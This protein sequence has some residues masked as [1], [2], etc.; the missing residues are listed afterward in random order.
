MWAVAS[1]FVEV[2]GSVQ[3]DDPAVFPQ[4][5]VQDGDVAEADEEFWVAAGSVEV[6]LVGDAVGAFAASCCDDRPN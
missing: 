2:E 1:C 3:P 5:H 6:Q 4:A